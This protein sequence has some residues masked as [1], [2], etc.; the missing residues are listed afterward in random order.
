MLFGIGAYQI[1]NIIISVFWR[2]IKAKDTMIDF[3]VTT[4][5]FLLA[6]AL[7]IM[8]L[9][10]YSLFIDPTVKMPDW[11]KSNDLTDLKKKFLNVI[12]LILVVDFLGEVVNWKGNAEILQLGISIGVVIAATAYYRIATNEK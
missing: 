3:V 10:L 11:M 4:D 7:Y 6:V 12:I 9:G 1:V 8:S 2:S 5:I